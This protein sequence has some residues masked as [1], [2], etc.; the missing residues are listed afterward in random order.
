MR[1][2][3]LAYVGGG[4]WDVDHFAPY[5]AH[6]DREGRPTDWFYDSFLFLMYGGAPSGGSYYNGTAT[7]ADWKFYLDLLFDPEHCLAALNTSVARAGEKLGDNA[8][9]IPI[10]IMIPYLSRTFQKFGDC[11]GDNV[12]E[13]PAQDA[14]RI[15]AFR[16]LV[17]EFRRRF[18][19]EDFPHLKLWGFYW[20]NEGITGA[21]E[22]V[23]RATADYLHSLNLGFH[24][25][26]W[27]RAPGVERWR[28]LGFDFVIMQP[29]YAFM[30]VPQ[31]AVAADEDRLA[32]NAFLAETLGMGVEMELDSATE[33][34]PGQR[35]ELQAYLNHGVSEASGYM[36]RAVGA[37]YQSSDYI[38]RLY[39]SDLPAC[40]RLY[41]DLYAFHKGTYQRRPISLC[42]GV[43]CTLNGVPA[44]LLTDGKWLVRPEQ[45]DRVLRTEGPARLEL[46]L[47]A[48]HLV[49][50]VR[51]RIVAT[52][53]GRLQPPYRVVVSTSEDGKTYT[54]A[55]D[56]S[57][58]A[59]FDFGGVRAGF[60]HVIFPPRRARAVR[61]GL[62]SAPGTILGVDEVCIFPTPHALWGVRYQLGGELL[63]AP[64]SVSGEELTDGRVAADPTAPGALRWQGAGRATFTC[65][66]PPL[67]SSVGAHFRRSPGSP[68]PRLRVSTD[69]SNP[70]SETMA[71]D[72]SAEGW[73]HVPLGRALVSTL[74]LEF[75][76][77][78]GVAWDEVYAQP[79]T[80]LARGKPYTVSPAFTARYGD[81]DGKELTDGVL[82]ERGF[83]DGRTVGWFSKEVT[84]WLDLG[85][86]VPVE[87][88]RLFTEG[89]GYAAV[90][91][92]DR[93]DLWG[94]SDGST[95]RLLRTHPQPLQLTLS[96]QA[97]G[98]NHQLAWMAFVV[99]ATPIRFLKVQ[100][101]A[102]GWLML[103][104]IEVLGGGVN[105][106]AGRPYQLT[107]QPDSEQRY[108][109]S[110][111]RLTDGDISRPSTGWAK[112]VGWNQGEPTVVVDLL[113]PCRVDMVRVHCLGGGNGAVYF[114]QELRIATSVD[115]ESWSEETV[116]TGAPAEAGNAQQ[117]TYMTARLAVR[118]ARF[119]RVAAQRRGWFM[120]DEVEAYGP[121]ETGPSG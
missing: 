41:D 62:E 7:L 12:A 109:D 27:F 76:G 22:A 10:L 20:M 120:V 37:Y 30:N 78:P 31:G 81:T 9:V 102:P 39:K 100:A 47:P 55:A 72:G 83:S 117:V 36:H 57:C 104:E 24:W 5:V 11:D 80:N 116:V 38:A 25:I 34:D 53:D 79:A 44:P 56:A 89:G 48:G 50:D 114:P 14:D 110:G 103:S 91:F 6:L 33:R 74:T 68:L 43:P 111:A 105:V 112:A 84:V 8:R 82:T 118:E 17:D 96:E 35:L 3:M 26:P 2:I 77:G 95:W 60:A 108:A 107:P 85:R 28:D 98:E 113:R 92:P 71:P 15:K 19:P 46:A 75:G 40:N 63:A 94:S 59:L 99:D 90:Q 58:P 93:V 97:A 87:A 115:G 49:G 18:H 4:A 65:T 88:V 32:Q 29:N 121:D 64:E 51:V 73:L 69:A 13:N 67:L 54:D 86:V 52:A 21:D 70:S 1:D 66:D 101:H 119:I 106:A 61:I 45:M 23:V 16:W 42:E